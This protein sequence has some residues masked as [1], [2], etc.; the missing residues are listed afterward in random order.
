MDDVD[1]LAVRARTQVEVTTESV[2]ALL[3]DK[4]I[5]LVTRRRGWMKRGLRKGLRRM[6]S[7]L[8][9]DLDRGKRATVGGL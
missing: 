8:E 4:F 2:P 9:E 5:E 1:A 3:T 7:I 6:Q